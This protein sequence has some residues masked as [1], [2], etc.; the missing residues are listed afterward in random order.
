MDVSPSQNNGRQ[1]NRQEVRAELEEAIAKYEDVDVDPTRM[2]RT[3]SPLLEMDGPGGEMLERVEEERERIRL[4]ILEEYDIKE[5]DDEETFDLKF[6]RAR[7][8]GA[9]DA[10]MLDAYM[11]DS[12][13]A[14]W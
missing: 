4:K 13:D 9:L 3:S 2:P 11:D 7:D 5:D 1:R 8:D 12:G 6:R 10:L 14:Y